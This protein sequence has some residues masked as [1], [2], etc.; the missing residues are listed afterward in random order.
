MTPN[1]SNVLVDRWSRRTGVAADLG[2]IVGFSL[3]TAVLAQIRIPLPFTPVPLT[4]Q[5]FAVLLAGAVL[6]SRRGFLSQAVYLAEGAAGLPVFAG[7]LGSVAHL[8]GPTG[9]YLWS[10]PLAAALVGWLVERGASRSVVKLAG[11]L[12]LSDLV[13][14]VCGALWLG[15]FFGTPWREAALLGFYP[16]LAGDVLKVALVGMTLPR[17]IS[18]V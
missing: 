16:F 8:L 1:V 11:A 10:F 2:W 15:H 3:L 12:V 4:G 7:G 6:G 9:G 18:R 17:V 14:L 13:I 5:T